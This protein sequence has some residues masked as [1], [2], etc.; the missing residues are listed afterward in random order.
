MR[1]T[2]ERLTEVEFNKLSK[3]IN[4]NYGIKLP[5]TKKVM[6]ES[7]LRKRLKANSIDS[8][9]EYVEYVFS[10][11]GIKKEL[12]HMIDV[13]STNKTDFFIKP[14]RISIIYFDLFF[15]L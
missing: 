2:L 3:L 12:V 4:T 15:G 10:D 5:I 9:K 11:I 1:D 14:F 7:R 13:V 6:L 8:F